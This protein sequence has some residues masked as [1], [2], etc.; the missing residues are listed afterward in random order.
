MSAISRKIAIAVAAPVAASIL[1]ASGQAKSAP[2]A[3]SGSDRS[4]I[5]RNTA[6]VIRKCQSWTRGGCFRL[7]IEV[8]G[9]REQPVWIGYR[10]RDGL[11]EHSH[12]YLRSG[13]SCVAAMQSGITEDRRG[14]QWTRVGRTTPARA[15]IAF[16]CD[17]P[18]KPGDEV[19]IDLS[20]SISEDGQSV[21]AE[22]FSFP[23]SPLE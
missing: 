16:G 7:L 22:R 10:P 6:P 9:T 17:G 11:M 13:T 18:I 14:S 8:S 4:V 21:T 2:P 1:L 15:I 3:A 23:Q 5:I 20:F 12:A 19:L